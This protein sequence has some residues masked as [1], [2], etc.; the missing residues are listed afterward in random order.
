M[1]QAPLTYGKFTIE[2]VALDRLDLL[3]KNAR[4]MKSETFSQLVSN[5]KKDGNLSQIPF[6]VPRDGGRFLVLSGNHRVQAALQAGLT[7][8]PIIYTTEAMSKDEEL[9]IQLSHNAISGQDDPVLLKELWNSIEQVDLKVYAGLDDKAL[10]QMLKTT[11]PP[12]GDVNL[13]FRT[14]SFMFL[15]DEVDKV[16]ETFRTA[17]EIVKANAMF[18]TRMAEYDRLLDSLADAGAANNVTNGATG[19]LCI[20]EVFER[21]RDDLL[22]GWYDEKTESAKHKNW[23]PLSSILGRTTIPAGAALVIKRAVD[24]MLEHQ[25]V[26]ATTRWQALEL[27][28]ADYLSGNGLSN[29]VERREYS[30]DHR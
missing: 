13:N 4:F 15:P 30:S 2:I 27:W 8:I 21:H 12:M 19:L 9:A 22:E 25:E 28:A 17:R 1:S 16:K 10:E 5:V 20:L 23:V 26:T 24:K 6:C 3:K 18:L 29:D 14:T 11:L 7:E